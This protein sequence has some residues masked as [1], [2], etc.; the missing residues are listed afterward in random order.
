MKASPILGR[1]LFDPMHF[2]SMEASL[3]WLLSLA[4]E[5]AGFSDQ[6][7]Y[8]LTQSGSFRAQFYVN[9]RANCE[10]VWTLPWDNI[11][12]F[13]RTI[14]TGTPTSTWE[15]SSPSVRINI[16]MKTRRPRCV[17]LG[18]LLE[19]TRRGLHPVGK[20][21]DNIKQIPYVSQA[22]P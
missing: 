2:L 19:L 16:C 9:I 8:W 18:C 1:L 7:L 20:Q 13:H 3:R 14:P 17:L 15:G 10:Q 4:L 21:R 11:L 12:P 22:L 5:Q 6:T